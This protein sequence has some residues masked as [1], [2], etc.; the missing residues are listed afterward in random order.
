MNLMVWVW[1]IAIDVLVCFTVLNSAPARRIIR[2]IR[3]TPPPLPPLTSEEGA[4][5]HAKR[6]AAIEAAGAPERAARAVAAAAA[7]ADWTARVAAQKASVRAAK[8]ASSAAY[9]KT[10]GPST[11]GRSG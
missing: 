8:A 1:G 6:L 2:W 4:A 9:L 10:H 11:P 7:K 5:V 3:Q